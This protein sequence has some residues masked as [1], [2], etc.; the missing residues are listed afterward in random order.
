MDWGAEDEGE[1]E[2]ATAF[3]SDNGLLRGLAGTTVPLA[4]AVAVGVERALPAVGIG[5]SNSGAM[6]AF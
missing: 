2:F 1:D 3:L 4:F 5:R 6:G